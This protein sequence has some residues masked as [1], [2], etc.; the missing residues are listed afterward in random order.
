MGQIEDLRTFTVIVD[1]KS[2]SKAA[3]TLNI[4]KSAVSR[5][6]TLLEER[7][8]TK[9][10]NRKP[11]QWN[12]TDI[13]QE[14]YDRATR[15]VSSFE[16]IES[17]FTSSH[18]NKS[19]PL[20]VS[21]PLDFGISYLL[22]T[23]L[24][25]KDENPEIQLTANFDDRLIDLEKDN[26]DFAIR[27]T[28]ATQDN[29]IVKKIGVVRHQLCASPEYLEKHGTPK[30]LE[31][32]Q[33]HKLLYFGAAKRGSWKLISQTTKNQ[34]LVEF[35]PSLNSNSGKFLLDAALSVQ[36]IANLPD[37]ILQDRITSNKLIPV[38]PLY[39]FPD[40]FIYLAH[41]EKRRMNRRMRLFSEKIESICIS[42]CN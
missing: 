42:E 2:I 26:Y 7:F 36:G 3:E 18:A 33:F 21:I 23:L 41:S 37:F 35:A 24:D 6:L 32:L 30:S 34:E 14:L 19:G 40:F 25:F 38:L 39:R 11:G 16:E 15:V 29:L 31:D 13:G 28:P 17:D 12:I 5:R 4:A 27:I 10:I 20:T 1:K 9:L 22:D 8:S